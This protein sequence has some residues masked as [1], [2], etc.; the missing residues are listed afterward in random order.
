MPKSRHRPN[1]RDV[2][3]RRFLT[4]RRNSSVKAPTDIGFA[5]L[6]KSRLSAVKT[7]AAEKV[8]LCTVDH[9]SPLTVV[10]VAVAHGRDIGARAGD[11]HGTF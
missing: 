3:Q 1:P 4:V 11:I 5:C 7:Q 8:S 10:I 9:V 2:L 6:A